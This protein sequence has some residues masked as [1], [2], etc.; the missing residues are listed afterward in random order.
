[1]WCLGT[2]VKVWSMVDV[3]GRDG[4][5]NVFPALPNNMISIVKQELLQLHQRLAKLLKI[6]FMS[7]VVNFEPLHWI[8]Q[9]HTKSVFTQNYISQGCTS[10]QIHRLSIS[11]A[12]TQT[13][14]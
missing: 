11:F 10:G 14:M 3:I 13:Q 5:G 9:L 1:M 2:E 4:R 12:I 8:W 7:H 6:N